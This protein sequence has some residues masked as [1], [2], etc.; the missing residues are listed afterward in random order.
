MTSPASMPSDPPSPAGPER[1]GILIS[2]LTRRGRERFSGTLRLDGSPGGTVVMRDG[3]VIAAAS[4]A[5]PGPEPLL[6]RSGRVAEDDWTAAFSAGAPQGRFAGELVRRGLLGSAG[7]EVVTRTAVVDA[8]FAMA[9]CGVHTCTAGLEGTPPL[10]PA[11]PGLEPGW[12]AREL[13]RRLTRADEWQ[14][15]GLTAQSRPW[16]TNARETTPLNDSRREILDRANGRR[17]PRDIAFALGRGFYS[18]MTDMAT[19]I[20]DGLAALDP[21]PAEAHAGGAAPVPSVPEGFGLPR[22]ERG[23]A[24]PG[25]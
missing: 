5:A 19:L 3:L 14:A 1:A 23:A 24:Y 12:L 20:D 9:L 15:R 8:L 11:D 13:T 6:L 18:V 2:A 7:I 17:T 16:A 10:L 25:E 21:P 4:P 22:R